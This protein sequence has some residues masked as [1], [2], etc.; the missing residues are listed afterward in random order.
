MIFFCRKEKSGFMPSGKLDSEKY[1]KVPL[2]ADIKCEYVKGRNPKNH[3]RYFAF[4]H[5]LFSS[6]EKFKDEDVFRRYLQVR[7]GYGIPVVINGLAMLMPDSI[8]YERLDES[9]FRKLFSRVIDAALI[10][11]PTWTRKDMIEIVQKYIIDFA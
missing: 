1:N 6:Q 3:A 7:A 5:I 8:A 4:I 2:G 9:E 10:E 11:F